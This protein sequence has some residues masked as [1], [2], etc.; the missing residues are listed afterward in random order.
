MMRQS[1]AAGWRK[2]LLV[3]RGPFLLAWDALFPCHDV[4]TARFEHYSLDIFERACIRADAEAAKR[5]VDP[6]I[7]WL[8]SLDHLSLDRLYDKFL[9]NRPTPQATIEA[10]W[11]S[12]RERGLAAM[13]EPE[14][15]ERWASCDEAAGEEIGR[16]IEKWGIR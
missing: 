16:R 6:K 14:V 1:R 5:P 12:L 9:R 3:H 10:I 7:Q 11:F 8:R 2:S 4:V 13:D 15:Q